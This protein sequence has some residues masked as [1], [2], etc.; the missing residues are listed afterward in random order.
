MN[1]RELGAFLRLHRERIRPQ[2]AGV[3][4]SG[5]RRTPGLRRE[6]VAGLAHVSTQ[7]YTRLEQGRGSLPSRPVLA[8]LARALRLD[9]VQ[10]RHLYA[11][12]GEAFS[13]P[14]GPP[15]DVPDHVRELIERLP[16]TAALVLG[17]AYD[18]LAWNRLGA[19]L[20]GDF[21]ALAP[22]E[23][24]LLR[25]YH[26]PQV[27]AKVPVV[28]RL[29]DDGAFLRSAAGQ[30]RIVMARYP[31]DGA[32]RHLVRDLLRDSPDFV[33]QWPAGEV[34]EVPHLRKTFD[35]PAV[36]VLELRCDLLAVPE[37]DQQVILYT[38][39]PGSAAESALRLLGVIG[40][41]R[42]DVSS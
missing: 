2:D 11:L 38:A 6:E 40:T 24:N 12:A 35:H 37:R 33:R 14:P 30:L 23:R 25:M 4:V 32:T 39:D 5:P 42:M 27:R 18:V 13:V 8:A 16:D 9:D 41:Q 10:R 29:L 19:A 28:G 3:P 36:G 17:A 7:H 31:G 34:V 20:F 22:R 15:S 1:Q 21:S 26:Q